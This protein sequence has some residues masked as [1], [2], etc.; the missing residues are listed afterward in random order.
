MGC[1]WL[2]IV[3]GYLGSGRWRRESFLVAGEVTEL[4]LN[5]V[6]EQQQ[7][8]VLAVENEFGQWRGAAQL[9]PQRRPL[10]PTIH[11]VHALGA[12]QTVQLAYQSTLAVTYLLQ[13]AQFTPTRRTLTSRQI[14]LLLLL[15][16]LLGQLS[17]ASLRGRLIEYQ[18]RLG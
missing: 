12:V 8:D 10:A 1:F 7:L 4:V 13:V 17:L 14:L 3:A 2:V 11:G 6:L 15:L 9:V 16:L 5:V 18:L